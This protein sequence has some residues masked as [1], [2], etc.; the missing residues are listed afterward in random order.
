MNYQST[1]IESE[2]AFANIYF[3][4]LLEAEPI[5]PRGSPTYEIENFTY[6]LNPRIRFTNFPSRK[7]SL[8]YI[9]REWQ[10]YL[11]ADPTDTR[12]AKYAKIWGPMIKD[13]IINSNY[14]AYWFK[15]QYG[16][17]EVVQELEQDPD[18]RRAVIPMLGVSQRHYDK[19]IVDKPCT[20][21]IEFRIRHGRLHTHVVMRSQDAVFGLGNDVPAFSF[22]SEVVALLLNQPL[23]YLTI[24]VGSFHYYERHK[25]MLSSIVSEVSQPILVPQMTIGD[26]EA[27]LEHCVNG[28]T[29]FGR[30]ITEVEL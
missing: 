21:S 13:G 16:V 29:E 3:K 14:G 17:K 15:G 12:I 18:S 22:L 2:Q 1:F 30:W 28:G 19:D 4:L 10:W 11:N 24:T 5:S 8:A 7:L 20:T 27:A 9:K 6:T 26:A 25:D 23:G